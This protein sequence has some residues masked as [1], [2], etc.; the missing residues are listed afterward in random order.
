MDSTG[1]VAMA[2]D[3]TSSRKNGARAR[4]TEYQHRIDLRLAA[5]ESD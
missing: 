5:L 1:A 3:E 4:R 2:K